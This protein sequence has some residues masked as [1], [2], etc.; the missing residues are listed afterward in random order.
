MY[1][2]G[3]LARWRADGVLEF[4]G[5]ADHQVK[6]R[7]FRIEPG[8][9][10]A[11]LVGHRSVSQA[12]VVARAGRAARSG[13]SATWWGRRA[14]RPIRRRCAPAVGGICPTTWCRRRSWC[15]SGCR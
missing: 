12:V 3:D 8:E 11:A 13:W 5:R 15:W 6:L 14:S 9:I 4:I 10:E 1:R 7:G 2:T